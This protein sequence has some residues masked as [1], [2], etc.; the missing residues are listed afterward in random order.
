VDEG[1]GE[2]RLTMLAGDTAAGTD[3]TLANAPDKPGDE[4]DEATAL[5]LE[6]REPVDE[7]AAA[8]CEDRAL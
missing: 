4:L 1:C 3:D 5:R 7:V 2:C 6:A 8:T